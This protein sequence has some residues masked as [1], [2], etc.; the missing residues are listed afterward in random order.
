MRYVK[1]M[2]YV[3]ITHKVNIM[4]DLNIS[5]YVLIFTYLKRKSLRKMHLKFK[6]LTYSYIMK[7]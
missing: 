2:R 5:H 4:H 3:N 7:R 6:A 1:I